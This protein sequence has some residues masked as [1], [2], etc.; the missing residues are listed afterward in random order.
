MKEIVSL[1]VAGIFVV[2][3]FNKPC[4]GNLNGQL[5]LCNYT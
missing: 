4:H 3:L 1:A 5:N 2:C